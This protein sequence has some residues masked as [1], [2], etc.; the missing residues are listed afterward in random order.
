LDGRSQMSEVSEADGR[1][2][3]YADDAARRADDNHE[4]AKWQM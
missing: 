4:E 1:T 3:D 2:A